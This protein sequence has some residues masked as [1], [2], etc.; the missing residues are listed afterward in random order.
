M[1]QNLNDGAN[2]GNHDLNNDG[3]AARTVTGDPQ[4]AWR[5]LVAIET[6]ERWI[7]GIQTRTGLALTAMLAF[8]ALQADLG[9][10]EA[11][12]AVC[13]ALLASIRP[14]WRAP[15]FLIATWS[16]ALLTL[17]FSS[18]ETIEHI[19]RVIEQTGLQRGLGVPLAEGMLVFVFALLATGLH[20]TRNH[21]QAWLSRHPFLVLLLLEITL[22]LVADQGVVPAEG[23]VALW[24]FVF[25]L[26][27]YI[28]YVPFAVMDLRAKAGSSLGTQLG[29]LQ[30]FWSPTYLPF[31]K[32]AAFLRKHLAVNR[33]ELAITHLKALKLLLWATILTTIRDG[34]TTIF[35][36]GLGIL[37]VSG[38]IDA[39]LSG[40]ANAVV[41]GWTALVL[42][43]TK[44]SLQVAIWAH[45][46]VGIARLAGYRLPRGSWRPLESRTLIEYFNRFHYYFKELLV[47]LFFLPTFMRAFRARPR[48]RIF[49]ATFMAAGVGNAI[50]HF[51][52]DLD[53]VAQFGIAHALESF[54]SYAFYSVVLAIGIGISQVRANAGFRP[55]NT[56]R[57]RLLSFFCVWG[58][59]VC[60]HVFSDG[61]R[62]HTFRQR[63]FFLSS[64]FGVP[65]WIMPHGLN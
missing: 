48:L 39:S 8:A 24:A 23:Q 62:E 46:F 54:T 9:T 6:N 47:D 63:A 59:V 17:S 30:P 58:F 5:S 18:S 31:G 44:F 26:M 21:P 14:G 3:S 12:L 50:W 1:S 40:A 33:R 19:D 20:W 55:G 38:A 65:A 28:W 35:Q 45:L 34:L 64:L 13:T 36:D 29:I 42:S 37:S 56:I 53:L 2:H 22:T 16:T 27:P 51:M 32:G 7:A 61:S 41:L 11:M 15:V 4:R 10:W 25:I 57:A 49:F 52:R 60:L 43:T